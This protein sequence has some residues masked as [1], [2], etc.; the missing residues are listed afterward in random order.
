MSQFWSQKIHNLTPYVP[1]EQPQ[2]QQYIKLN[3]NESP[4][5]P[6]PQAIAAMKTACDD[7][8]RLYPDPQCL[9][10][11]QSIA[12]Y[13]DL[14]VDNVFVGN[15]SDEV[16]AFS[17]QGFFKQGK[18]LLYPDIS[19]SFYPVYCQLYDIDTRTVPLDN[20]FGIR[21][22][23]YPTDNGGIIFPNPNAPTG[24]CLPLSDIEALLQ[25][26]PESVVVIDE[27]Y[28]DFGGESA[29]ALVPRYNNLLV[30]QTFSKSRA[31]AGI[32]VGF[33]LGNKELVEGLE[34]LKNS[35]NS[36]PLDR[37]AL[38]GA[39][40]SLEDHRY[41]EQ[42][43]DQLISVRE[44]TTNELTSLGFEVIPSKANF[45]FASHPQHAAK[46]IY[47]ALKQRGILVRYFN[48]A[49]IDNHL[50]IS[51]GT[52]QEMQRFIEVIRSLM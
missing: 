2:D 40:A 34:R 23:D 12:R 44:W 46:G 14:S 9:S 52:E 6:S 25:R 13:Y 11:K 47:D 39:Q 42:R 26:N 49:R 17:F 10:L 27:A 24:R 30:I 31:M 1:G 20:S 43:R 4:Y 3:T 16:L 37:P 19:Y 48:K 32:R 8:L 21:L 41:F 33:A 35:F 45:L 15:G 18:P 5:G 22:E 36:Y 28:I 7:A 29:A 38:A 51:I 50:R